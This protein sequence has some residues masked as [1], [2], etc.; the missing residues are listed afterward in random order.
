MPIFMIVNAYVVRFVSSLRKEK[1]LT[2]LGKLQL[3]VLHLFYNIF[4]ILF[5]IA[6]AFNM[7]STL[8]SIK[9]KLS[10]I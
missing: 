6:L 9:I 3:Q 7:F 10:G 8:M 2:I 1:N 5:Q 4:L